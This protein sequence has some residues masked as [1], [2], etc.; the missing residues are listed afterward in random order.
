MTATNLNF[1]TLLEI[2]EDWIMRDQNDNRILARLVDGEE[3]VDIPIGGAYFV[4]DH[5]TI[6]LV[7]KSRNQLDIFDDEGNL[8][9]DETPEGIYKN[10]EMPEN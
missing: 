3:V 9:N 4:D 7:T 10:L 2:T 8:L 6:Y 5:K 1:G